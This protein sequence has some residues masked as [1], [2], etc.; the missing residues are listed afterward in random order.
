MAGGM[1]RIFL[2]LGALGAFAGL[3]I[4]WSVL[5]IEYPTFSMINRT[6]FPQ[7]HRLQE[8]RIVEAA[9]VLLLNLVATA[10]L[11]WFAPSA[12]RTWIAVA[13]VA[14]VAALAWGVSVQIPAHLVLNKTG[15][16]PKLLQGMARNEWVR[17]LAVSIHAFAYFVLLLDNL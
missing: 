17:F 5:R 7:V 2:T 1:L 8:T 13:M 15:S 14:I 4:A 16:D 12:Q 9:P 10:A 6:D 3:G 11:F